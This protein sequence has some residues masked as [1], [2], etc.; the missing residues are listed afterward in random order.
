MLTN[1]PKSLQSAC[2]VGTGL[3]NFH[4]MTVSVLKTHFRKFLPRIISYR[5][6]SDY[7]NT[8]FINSLNE[9]HLEEESMES[10]LKDPNYFHKVNML[11][12][13]KKYILENNISFLNKILSKAK[14][15]K[16][17]L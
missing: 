15:L 7:K 11:H 2:A 12:V 5:D 1:R 8:N 17:K 4:R 13:R 6:F 10:F 14:M 3:Y 16:T 9:L